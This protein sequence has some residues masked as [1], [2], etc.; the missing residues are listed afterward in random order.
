MRNWKLDRLGADFHI[1]S[2][3][4]LQPPSPLPSWRDLLAEN[5]L[6]EFFT[7]QEPER[8]DWESLWDGD[9]SS[10]YCDESTED[11]DEEEDEGHNEDLEPGDGAPGDTGNDQ[12]SEVVEDVQGH[13][14]K[15][16]SGAGNGS[17]EHVNCRDGDSG[18]EEKQGDQEPNEIGQGC[19]LQGIQY[20]LSA[21]QRNDEDGDA[22]QGDEEDSDSEQGHGEQNEEQGLLEDDSDPYLDE[23][24]DLESVDWSSYRFSQHS[25]Y[26]SRWVAFWQKGP[27][28][29]R[30]RTPVEAEE[31]QVG[32][33]QDIARVRETGAAQETGTAR[34]SA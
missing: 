31:E 29:R 33:N 21:G 15:C 6:P 13:I 17:E 22:E 34:E 7:N 26:L 27:H 11:E 4:T 20:D 2:Y 3:I 12:G 14:Q 1:D 28:Y 19:E 5:I 9:S 32:D 23:A 10:E 25:A 30:S 8:V 16:Q 24:S 18:G